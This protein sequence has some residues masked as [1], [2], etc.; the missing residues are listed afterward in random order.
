[1]RKLAI[2]IAY[3]SALGFST[4]GFAETAQERGKRVVYEA[5][6]ALGGNAFLAME[7]RVETGRIYS[8]YR[9]SLQS[10]P[11]AKI[12]TR[13]VAP[14]PRTLSVRERRN[15]FNDESYG[16]LYTETGAWE[17]TFRGARPL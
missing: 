16:L 1:M 11:K 6:D 10:L 4:A 17:I 13:Y 7:D 9:D 3:V 14:S 5:L 12:Y 2:A 15:Y 8:F